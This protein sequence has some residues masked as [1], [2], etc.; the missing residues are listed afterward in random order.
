MIPNKDKKELVRFL[1]SQNLMAVATI[2]KKPWIATCY[3]AIDKNLDI[4]FVSP[5][6]SKHSKD[7]EKDN[8]VACAM[9]DSHT[10][11]SKLKVGV[12]LQGRATLV[13]GWERT[14]VLLKMWN[15]AAPGAEEI[16]NVKNMKKKVISSRVYKIKPTLIKFFNQKLYKNE[17]EMIFTL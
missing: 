3:Y 7:I 10:P 13:R 8:H 11:N 16:I 12:Q 1:K 6:S 4:F 2:D 15:R 14:K 5:P 9:Y 17:D